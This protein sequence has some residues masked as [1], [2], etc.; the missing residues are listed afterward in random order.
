MPNA[1]P[2]A[3]G[4]FFCQQ[5][6]GNVL[7]QDEL[8]RV[9]VVGDADHPGFCRV[10][11]NRHVKEMTD[12]EA[13]GRERLMRIVFEVE[14]ALRELLQPDK[15]NLASLG[16]QVPH[17]HWHVIPRYRDD[18]HYPNPVWGARTAATP[19]SAGENFEAALE[20]ALKHSLG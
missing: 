9:V 14:R 18:P 3:S 16:N 6:G 13:E 8:A 11:A 17:L 2:D 20:R 10:I 1:N 15:I 4:C 5:P 12:L 7:W 19:R